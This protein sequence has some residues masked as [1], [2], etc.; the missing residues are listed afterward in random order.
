M[1][2]SKVSIEHNLGEQT[3]LEKQNGRWTIKNCRQTYSFGLKVNICINFPTPSVIFPA[4]PAN[5]PTP[6]H[7]FET[8]EK[9]RVQW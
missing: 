1:R 3:A 6:G 8:E 7:N 4:R 5:I 2:S 9:N